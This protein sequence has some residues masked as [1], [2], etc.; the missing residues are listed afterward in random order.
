MLADVADGVLVALALKRIG[1]QPQRAVVPRGVREKRHLG[2]PES[3]AQHVVE[4][5]ILQLVRSDRVFRLLAGLRVGC[6]GRI[7]RNQLRTHLGIEDGEQRRTAFRR[8]E[9]LMR[10]PVHEVLDERL[11]HTRVDVVVRHVIAYAVGAPAQRELAQI[12]GADDDAAVEIGEPEQV[13]GA[14]AGLHV[15]EGDVVHRLAT[16]EWMAQVGQHLLAARADVDL[17]RG[18]ADGRHE[19]VCL[20]QR[21]VAG[22]EAGHGEAEDVGARKLQSV[23]CLRADQQRMGRVQPT[24]Y[25]D[26]H[27]VDVTG[28][29]S[30]HQRLHLDV[31]DFTA[32]LV[33][34]RCAGR[35]IGKTFDSAAQ[36]A[37][38]GD[39][40]FQV[41][42]DRA[43]AR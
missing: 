39:G 11:R 41:E 4:V 32:A 25:A 40:R 34:R 18:A 24:R 26:H 3:V 1:P 36:A 30:L 13:A 16:A 29:Q 38:H 9:F 12:A 21:A 33:E 8:Q 37:R 43:P 35:H 20:G 15:L 5:E 10:D 2:R 7:V 23:H 42:L 14:L 27:L 17:A 31:E 28:L 22:R 19:L 6:A